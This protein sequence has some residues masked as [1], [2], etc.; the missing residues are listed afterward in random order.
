MLELVVYHKFT[1]G[2]ATDHSGWG[3]HGRMFGPTPVAGRRRGLAFDGVDDRV[4][5]LPSASLSAMGAIRTLV[6]ARLDV[7]GQRRTLVEGYLSFSLLVESDG[8]LAG[9]VYVE[10][11]W[12]GVQSTAGTILP[13]RWLDLELTYDGRDTFILRVGEDVV[14]SRVHVAGPVNGVQWPFGLNI[15]AWPDADRR[16]FKGAIKQVQ[17]WRAAGG[18]PSG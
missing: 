6:S 7:G 8:S 1:S 3:N 12:R 9:F 17:V 5:V 4:V 10:N 16:M 14:G 18:V 11:G 2:D 13:G 15:G